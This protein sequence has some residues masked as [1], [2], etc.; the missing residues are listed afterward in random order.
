MRI[1]D[2]FL[3]KSFL[4][5]LLY[6]LCLFF[7]LYVIIDLFG[8]LDEILRENIKVLILL[9]YYLGLA[10]FIMVQTSPV[11]SL[12]SIIYILSSLN[13]QGGITAM[14]SAGIN[15]WRLITP[16]ILMGVLLSVLV[17]LISETILPSQMN[18]VGDLKQIYLE[19]KKNLEGTVNNITFFGTKNRLFFIGAYELKNKILKDITILEHDADENVVS[20]ITAHTAQWQKDRWVSKEVLTYNLNPN[21]EIKGEPIFF[22]E[23]ALDIDEKPKDLLSQNIRWEFASSR[24]LSALLKRFSKSPEKLIKTIQ[25]ELYRKLSLPLN[26]LVLILVGAAFSLRPKKGGALFGIGVSLLIGF[27]YYVVESIS[28]A[29]GKA[30]VLPPLCS[31]F[32]ANFLFGALGIIVIAKSQ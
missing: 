31:A 29:L 22:N 2:R 20:K 14:S 13:K 24:D 32:L 4:S 5:P 17:F 18:K 11:A 26:S 25:V 6:C 3:I 9:K 15:I 12:I 16:F 21:G 27:S 7:F 8:H 23:Q 30:T 28:I 10:P 1:L 19:K